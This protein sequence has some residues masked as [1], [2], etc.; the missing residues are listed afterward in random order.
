M[1]YAGAEFATK[2]IHAIQGKKGIIVP[3]FVSLTADPAGGEA[4]KKEIEA[5][6]EFFS[7]PVELGVCL[8]TT[9]YVLRL[10]DVP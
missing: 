8:P 3:S 10:S 4:L 6:L 2:V 7:A 5:D 1:A 9:I